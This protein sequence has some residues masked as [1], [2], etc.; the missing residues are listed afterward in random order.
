MGIHE[1]K[2]HAKSCQSGCFLYKSWVIFSSILELDY[3]C[4]IMY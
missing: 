2:E 1:E 4:I 3:A